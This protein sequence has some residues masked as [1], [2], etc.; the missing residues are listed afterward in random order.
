MNEVSVFTF[1]FN[2]TE[3][4][5][6][7]LIVSESNNIVGFHSQRNSNDTVISLKRTKVKN[8]LT[9]FIKF[10]FIFRIFYI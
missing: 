7:I 6:V 10:T 4:D 8:K 2:D 3:N 1:K 9:Q 5:L